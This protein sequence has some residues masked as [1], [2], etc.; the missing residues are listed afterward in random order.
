MPNFTKQA[1]QETF[2]RLLDEKPLSQISVR[3]IVDECGINRNTFYYH[4][5]DIPALL[6]EIVVSQADRLIREHSTIESLDDCLEVVTR[7]IRE[8]RRV[9][10]HIYNSLSR[11]VFEDYLMRICDYTVTGH[12]RVLASRRCVSEEDLRILSRF[13]RD[14]C[15]GMYID[16]VRTGIKDDFTADLSRFRQMIKSAIEAEIS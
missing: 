7:T 1:I 2:L 16:W 8:N 9:M 11:D 4:Y 6:R 10:Y 13:L 5:E 3:S 15:F 12:L 14:V